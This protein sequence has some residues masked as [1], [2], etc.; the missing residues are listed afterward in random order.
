MSEKLS[1]IVIQLD[2]LSRHF[3]YAYGNDWVYT[4]TLQAFTERACTFDQHY[5]GSLP[6]M[7]A[8]REIWAGTEEFWWRPWGPLEP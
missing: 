3:L 4:P 7:P 1:L 2:S 8:R 6:C 5:V